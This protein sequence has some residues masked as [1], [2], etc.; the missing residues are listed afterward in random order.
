M[1]DAV[2]G[3]DHSRGADQ[4]VAAP[5]HRRRPGMGLLPGDGDLVP[6]LA[7]RPGYDADRL[8]CGFEDRPLLDMRLEIGGGR[9]AADRLRAGK[10]DALELGAERDA[11]NV[12]RPRET[13]GE[14]EDA[15]EHARADH[16][17]RK[18]R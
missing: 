1:A 18:A 14:V 10:A 7:L 8:L 9:P 16:R 11:G 12:V 4:R 15:G 17:R 13:L 2:D 5:R 6:A 3:I